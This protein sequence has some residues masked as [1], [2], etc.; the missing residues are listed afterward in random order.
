MDFDPEKVGLAV[1]SVATAGVAIFAA[2]RANKRDDLRQQAEVKKSADD[3]AFDRL[4]HYCD[5]QQTQIDTLIKRDGEKEQRLASQQQQL[6]ECAAK[7][8]EC[9]EGRKSDREQ[10][11]AT[12]RALQR[13]IDQLKGNVQQIT[14]GGSL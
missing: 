10:A 4:N 14:N 7:H 2:W 3:A 5:R 6:D 1:G 9:E 13:Q 12:H 11:E 8:E